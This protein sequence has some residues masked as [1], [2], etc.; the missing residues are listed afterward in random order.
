M[1]GYELLYRAHAMDLQCRE[2]GDLMAS[3][4]FT[5][6][7]LGIG[8]DRLTNGAPAFINF[9]RQL[10][11]DQAAL[12]LPAQSIV[13]E[14]LES[15]VVDAEVIGAC[16]DLHARGYTMAL[17]DFVV[18]S[19]AEELLPYARFVKL[20]VLEVPAAN[21]QPVARRFASKSMK[22]VA[23]RVETFSVAASAREAGCSLFQG[24]YFCRPATQNAPALPASR[25]AYLNL[26]AALNQPDLSVAALEDLVKRDVS[27]SL[28]VLRSINSAGFGLGQPIRSLRHALVMLGVQQVRKWASVWAMA[29]V[30]AGNPPELVSV[31]LLRARTCE[32]IGE[33]WG[34]AE[35][36]C[37]LF[38]LGMCSLLDAI[39]DQPME[40]ALSGLQLSA[41]VREALLGSQNTRRSILDAV[42][43]YE[44]G[45]WDEAA[46]TLAALNVPASLLATAYADA[47]CWARELAAD[48]VAV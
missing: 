24:H 10:L 43:A 12:L 18:G 29:G 28:R 34:G 23:E 30:N 19:A 20:D 48:S 21:W 11:I 2:A 16:R 14:L 46:A 45:H 31:A 27:L 1:L 5:D 6:A 17:D 7:I 9:T 22:V 41:A 25:I 44:Q 40:R 3:R 15:I 4:A 8:L 37:E 35:A 13:V 38:L 33:A 39:L 26:F 32:I 47:L 42:V 36:G